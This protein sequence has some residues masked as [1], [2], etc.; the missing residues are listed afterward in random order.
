V[1]TDADLARMRHGFEL[2]NAE[3]FESIGEFVTDDVVMERFDGPPLRGRDALIEFL[4]P[5]VFEYQRLFP[6]EIEVHGDKL[7]LRLE[8]HAKGAASEVEL[9]IDGW[10]VWTLRDGLAS[11]IVNARDEEEARAR[12]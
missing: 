12:L 7:L 10:Q 6:K 4:K 1:V 8:I 3:Q 5:D 9:T 2:F 11:H